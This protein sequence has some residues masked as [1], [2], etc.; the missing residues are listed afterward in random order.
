MKALELIIKYIVY[1]YSFT[2]AF[3]YHFAKGFIRGWRGVECEEYDEP[4]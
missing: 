1:A 4:S 2:I 3:P